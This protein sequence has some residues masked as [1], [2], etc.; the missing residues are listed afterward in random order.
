M[1][2]EKEEK[3]EKLKIICYSCKGE[4]KNFNFFI[5]EDEKQFCCK[6]CFNNR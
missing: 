1:T 5:I 4:I 2:E 6:W 3:E